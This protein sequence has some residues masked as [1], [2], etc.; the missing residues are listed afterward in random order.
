MD[1]LV[2]AFTRGDAALV[3][4]SSQAAR[5]HTDELPR[6]VALTQLPEGMRGKM[7]RNIFNPN[8]RGSAARMRLTRQSAQTYTNNGAPVPRP[9]SQVTL[10][11]NA[12]G[13][14]DLRLVDLRPLVFVQQAVSPTTFLPAAGYKL[15]VRLQVYA[16]CQ[17]S[18]RRWCLLTQWKQFA[19]FTE[20][21]Q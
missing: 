4:L 2:Y 16:Q 9:Y 19:Y 7:L 3:V 12:N 18:M 8:V 13:S 14:A 5:N 17:Q 6:V 21:C 1:G 20:F 10:K 11:V 15:L